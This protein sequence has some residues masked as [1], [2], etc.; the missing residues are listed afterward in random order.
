[1]RE[2]AELTQPDQVYW[3]DGSQAE[4]DALTAEQRSQ[5]AAERRAHFAELRR[6]LGELNALGLGLDTLSMGMSGDFEDAIA[7]G[8]THVRIGTAIF[9]ERQ[10]QGKMA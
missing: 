10:P 9:G 6:L 5:A 4:W 7:E 3:C 1:M 8:A 2:I